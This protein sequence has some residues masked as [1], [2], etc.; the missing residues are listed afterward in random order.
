MRPHAHAGPKLIVVIVFII[1]RTKR[2][3]EA[4]F[5]NVVETTSKASEFV[6]IVSYNRGKVGQTGTGHFS[7]IGGYHPRKDMVLLMEVARFKYPPHWIPLSML[8]EATK[9]PTASL[10]RPFPSSTYSCG[11]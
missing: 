4:T 3:D 11:V 2:S 5:R 8:F 1:N 10:G 9:V 7:P 6:S